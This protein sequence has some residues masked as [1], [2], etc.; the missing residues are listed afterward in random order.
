MK[1]REFI[2]K[3]EKIAKKCGDDARVVMADNVPVVAPIF[4]E[5]YSDKKNIVITDE[6]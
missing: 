1:L 6:E 4:S 5:K 2:E 3:L